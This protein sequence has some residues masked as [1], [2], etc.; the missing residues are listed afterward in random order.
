MPRR[1]SR[2]AGPEHPVLFV[3]AGDFP[4][5][6]PM[7][8]RPRA[9]DALAPFRA[10]L[11]AAETA[12]LDEL[13]VR[14]VGGAVLVAG[15]RRPAEALLGGDALLDDGTAVL[16]IIVPARASRVLRAALTARFVL[17]S[18]TLRST[19]GVLAIEPD[20]CADLRALAREWRGRG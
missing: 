14:R 8:P 16:P 18:G 4:P 5:P 19:E 7:P 12:R 10:L 6:P 1:L 11:A 17:I 13:D 15:E 2:R 3:D 9:A 20:E